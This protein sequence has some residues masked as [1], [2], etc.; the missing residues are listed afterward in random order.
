MEDLKR[1]EKE[2]MQSE[3]VIYDIGK[4]YVD[5]ALKAAQSRVIYDLAYADAVD[6]IGHELAIDEK[7]KM[8]AP[9]QAAE[10][11]R[12]VREQFKTCREAEGGVE[13]T[14]KFLEVLRAILSSCQTRAKLVEIEYSMNGR[15]I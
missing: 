14:K 6:A 7:K 8:T 11:L 2:L 4:R 13:G 15:H 9:Q 3:Q 10:A 5:D 1:I 12:R